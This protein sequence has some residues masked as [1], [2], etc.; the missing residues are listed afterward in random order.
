MPLCG[1]QLRNI[2]LPTQ[3][4]D[5]RMSPYDPGGRAGGIQQDQIEET[6]VPPAWYSTR[7]RNNNL[8]LQPKALDIAKAV[9]VAATPE[10][11]VHGAAPVVGA[12]KATA[13]N[14]N[15]P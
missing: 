7:I 5:I 15:T 8:R 3:P 12:P 4:T 9:D 13:S 6:S 1:C 14:T 11:L 2:I 10:I